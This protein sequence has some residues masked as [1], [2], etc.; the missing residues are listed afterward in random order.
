MRFTKAP[1]VV[2]PADPALARGNAR[3]YE[4]LEAFCGMAM[5]GLFGALF[6][7]GLLFI[8][9]SVPERPS[10]LYITAAW[11]IWAVLAAGELLFLNAALKLYNRRVYPLPPELA[12]SQP[13]WPLL[14]RPVATCWWL[15]HFAGVLAVGQLTERGLEAVR[16]T[17]WRQ[18]AARWGLIAFILFGASYAA[19]VYLLMTITSLRRS[20]RAVELLW[21]TRFPLDIL[22]TAAMLF[23]ASKWLTQAH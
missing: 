8:L 17:D 16:P 2:V 3:W 15:A 14:L 19:N 4:T 1:P 9:L 5:A 13:R 21:R 6:I 20:R 12:L 18:D 10:T 7:L 11:C 22:L 23:G